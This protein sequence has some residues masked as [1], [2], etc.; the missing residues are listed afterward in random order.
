MQL[1]FDIDTVRS[2]FIKNR[3]LSTKGWSNWMPWDC[4]VSCGG[5]TGVRNRICFDPDLC[6]GPEFEKGNATPN[7]ALERPMRKGTR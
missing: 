2:H 1:D 5:G 6:E 7:P 3:A 4:S